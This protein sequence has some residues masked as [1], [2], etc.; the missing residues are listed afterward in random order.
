M[1]KLPIGLHK[2]TKMDKRGK[3]ELLKTIHVRV[4]IDEHKEIDK[5]LKKYGVT[6]SN[7]IRYAI[8]LGINDIK[9]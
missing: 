8:Q 2:N 5:I 4:T 7:F 9:D 3:G 1:K 6:Q